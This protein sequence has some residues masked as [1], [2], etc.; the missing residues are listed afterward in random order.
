MSPHSVLVSVLLW[1]MLSMRLCFEFLCCGDLCLF[2]YFSVMS[3]LLC[4]ATVAS[5]VM[6]MYVYVYA[7]PVSL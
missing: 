5:G 4:C 2:Y 1:L 7:V 6:C 3:V